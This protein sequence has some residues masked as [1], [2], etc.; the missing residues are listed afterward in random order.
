MGDTQSK[1]QT[2]LSPNYGLA[3]VSFCFHLFAL[4]RASSSG[5]HVDARDKNLYVDDMEF[6]GERNSLRSLEIGD[7]AEQG[8]PYPSAEQV[9]EDLLLIKK[10]NADTNSYYTDGP[11]YVLDL[12]EKHDLKVLY[13][14]PLNWWT[15]GSPAYLDEQQRI[16]DK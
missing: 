12:A 9:E 5:I 4:P 8:Y 1:C 7:G 2:Y 15:I 14:F 13:C 6:F 16:V 3:V 10:L 11:E